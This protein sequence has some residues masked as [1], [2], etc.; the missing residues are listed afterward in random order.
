VTPYPAT[1]HE[2]L[3]RRA[4]ERRRPFD[5]EGGGYRDSLV[6][7]TILA[8]LQEDE[9]PIWLVSAD[10]KAFWEGKPGGLAYDLQ[11]DLRA[12]NLA[13]AVVLFR[14]V[15]ELVDQRVT[16]GL[17][18]L[19]THDLG[20]ALGEWL[21]RHLPGLLAKDRTWLQ[22]LFG[23]DESHLSVTDVMIESVVDERVEEVRILP[24]G[25]H[26]ARCSARAIFH[27][28]LGA[29]AEDYWESNDV[30]WLFERVVHGPVPRGVG[31]QMSTGCRE[32]AKVTLEI[33]VVDG[34]SSGTL[35]DVE[36]IGATAGVRRR[37]S[38][39]GG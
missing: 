37:P 36:P 8:L 39:L 3:V 29:S 14:T 4:I 16:P 34:D 21:R 10:G 9:S 5:D 12:R 32:E 35:I 19:E 38:A 13:G 28:G 31:W 7:E 22:P 24:S 23:V 17:Q 15:K 33:L 20:F 30:R 1:S 6:W 11:E 18:I 26:F 25:G 27:F 2:L